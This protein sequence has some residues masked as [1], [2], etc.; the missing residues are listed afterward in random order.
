M[1]VKITET[2][3]VERVA[4]VLFE[5]CSRIIYNRHDGGMVIGLLRMKAFPEFNNFPINIYRENTGVSVAE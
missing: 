1:R 3:H 4:L 2:D 5:K